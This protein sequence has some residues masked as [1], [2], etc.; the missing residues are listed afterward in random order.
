[1]ITFLHFVADFLLAIL[2][3]IYDR[4]LAELEEKVDD[5]ETRIMRIGRKLG[6]PYG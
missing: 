6:R 4:R 3:F 1:M 2:V 5:L